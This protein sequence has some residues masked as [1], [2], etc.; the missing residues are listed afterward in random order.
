MR[1]K[2]RSFLIGAAGAASVLAI[3]RLAFAQVGAP[4]S[5]S[6]P[7]AVALGYKVDVKEVDKTKFPKYA[8]GQT[9][10]N[11][12]L[13]QAKPVDVSGPC[14]LFQNKLVRSQGW[15]SAWVKKA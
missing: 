10:S 15:C 11:C 5:E 13:Y 3:S 14:T 12:Q 4:L 8:A 2:R 7:Q 9:C 6:D 1:H